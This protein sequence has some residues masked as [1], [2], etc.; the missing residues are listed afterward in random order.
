MRLFFLIAKYL[1]FKLY[2]FFC[3]SIPKIIFKKAKI[4]SNYQF[5]I[6]LRITIIIS[7][8]LIC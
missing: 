1:V 2:D 3:I 8:D 7:Y 4:R 6:L 5:K